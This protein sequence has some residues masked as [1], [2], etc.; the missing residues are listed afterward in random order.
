MKPV[1]A[2]LW[3]LSIALA[4]GLTRLA[5]PGD[6]ESSPSFDEAFAE[7]DPLQRAYLISRSLQNLDPDNLPELRTA[8]EV[9]KVGILSEEVRLI[10]LAWARFDA[11]GAYAWAREGPVNW[12]TTLTNQAIYA[13]AHHDA[14]AALRVVEETED[15]ELQ[16]R[17]RQNL[18]EGWLRS[19]DK[20]GISEYIANFP[21]IKQRGRLFFR[22]AG[23]IMLAEGKDGA[24][25]WAE[26]LPDDAPNRLKLG[27]FHHIAKMV[28]KD[29]PVLAA[30]WFLAHRTRPYSE[31]ALAGI[32]R[33]WVQNHDR[34]AAFE[35]LLA[36]SSDGLRA[37][38]RDSAIADG[39]RTWMQADPEAAQ[40]WLLP[41]LPNPAL[42]PAIK[43]AAKRLLPTAPDSAMAW[44]Q[45]IDDESERHAQSVRVGIRWRGK[46][47]KA[48][49][50][51][52]KESD[53][54]EETRQKI[55]K[56]RERG[57]PMSAKS[58]PAAA[59]KP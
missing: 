29:D 9:R 58:K 46:D 52:L 59:G 7:F 42:D 23:E 35:W 17:L 44:A 25:R 33:R 30:E 28:A 11:P 53:L 47:P 45:R 22:L 2:V 15:P 18:I 38:E 41:M 19:D 55:L 27:I 56:V 32:A 39:F 14:P 57:A 21:D 34:P 50:D 36:M 48:F 3:I 31:G 51:W 5:D 49:N 37:G 6:S 26:A 43:E 20:E 54:S 16:A 12:R 40:A 13:W 24:M 10:M 1:I 8:L 4:I